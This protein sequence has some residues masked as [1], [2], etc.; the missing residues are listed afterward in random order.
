MSGCKQRQCRMGSRISIQVRR[1]YK[2][3]RGTP[4]RDKMR[5]GEVVDIGGGVHEG[6]WMWQLGVQEHCGGGGFV[7]VRMRGG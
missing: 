2:W 5:D 1:H 3:E 6:G 7:G 4:N